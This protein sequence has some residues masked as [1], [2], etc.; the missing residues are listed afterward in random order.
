[1]DVEQG[2]HFVLPVGDAASQLR[3]M[4]VGLR[5]EGGR[6]GGREERKERREENGVLG[7]E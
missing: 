1:L 6:E 3:L 2:L 4:G 7:V 5:K